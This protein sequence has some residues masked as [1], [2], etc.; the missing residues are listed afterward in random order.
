MALENIGQDDGENTD[1][2]TVYRKP[3]Q[4]SFLYD[5]NHPFAGKTPYDEGGEKT[6]YQRE[7]A[8]GGLCSFSRGWGE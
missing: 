4:F 3:N 1:Y 6:D 5:V 7:C 2:G 8:Y